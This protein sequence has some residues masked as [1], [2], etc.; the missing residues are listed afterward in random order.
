M[1]TLTAT[2]TSVAK[3]VD[4]IIDVL[5]GTYQFFEPAGSG[6]GY[7]SFVPTPNASVVLSA[8]GTGTHV[9]GSTT[10]VTDTSGHFI[11]TYRNTRRVGTKIIQ[12]I[13][14]FPTQTVETASVS[15]SVV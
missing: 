14:T 1:I 15:V 11:T 8:T 10:G 2:P 7:W 13:V 12:S 5:A 6:S 3:N 4:T 9:F